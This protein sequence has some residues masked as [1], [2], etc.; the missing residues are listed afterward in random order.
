M[1]ELQTDTLIRPEKSAASGHL[2]FPE[3]WNFSEA[4]PRAG[5]RYLAN[6]VFMVAR[7]VNP[8]VLGVQYDRRIF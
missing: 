8:A 1:N 7:E 6:V 5:M 3:E 4:G 2:Q